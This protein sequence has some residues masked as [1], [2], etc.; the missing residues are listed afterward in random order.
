MDST[1]NLV[2]GRSGN[3]ASPAK[4]D[5]ARAMS[6]ENVELVSTA[7]EAWQ[8]EG[9]EGLLSFFH[10]DI[11]FW[12]AEEERW[13]YGHQGVRSNLEPWFEAW[14]DF[15]T[16]VKEVAGAGTRVFAALHITAKGRGSGVP[17]SMLVY[18]VYELRDGL[19]VRWEEY[20]DRKQAL[21]AA[22]LRE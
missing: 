20:V 19:A 13:L 6:R 21:R 17:V 1:S 16:E 11:E 3:F 8:R 2:K 5:T 7:V 4:R 22:G 9:V 12:P 18:H 10:P 15:R 14:E